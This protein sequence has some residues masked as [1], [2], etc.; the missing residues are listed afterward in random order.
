M[1]PCV[2]RTLQGPSGC[3]KTTCLDLIAGRKTGAAT[4]GEILF[5]GE[6]PTAAL[7]KRCVGYVS[8]GPLGRRGEGAAACRLA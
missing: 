2:A 3:G 8:P 7:L 6:R 4:Q 5:G 1:F